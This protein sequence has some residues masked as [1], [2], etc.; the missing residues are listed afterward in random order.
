MKGSY[1]MISE[2]GSLG[3]HMHSN[4]IAMEL[5]GKG[6]VL[7]PEGGIG[8]SYFQPDYVEYYSQFPAHNTV[9][10]DGISKYPEMKSNHP[11]VL[12][13]CYPATGQKSG[14]FPLINYSDVS[15]L[16]PET[17]ADQN[18]LMS[19]IRTSDSTGYY[20]DVFRSKRKDGK[21]KYHDYFY[22]NLGQELLIKDSNGKQLDLKPA[23]KLSFAQGDLFAYDYL[24]DKKS[25]VTGND[26]KGIYKLGIPGTD[27][28][29]MN[30]WMKG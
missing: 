5:Y 18:R 13:S 12:K 23:E 30:A 29:F 28:I 19:I 10:V 25:I 4:G 11:F 26:I 6:I 9:V 20:V 8:T 27:S 14:Y 2:A 17:N 24:W 22:H 15:F 7:A 16:E 1:G 3:N 21:D